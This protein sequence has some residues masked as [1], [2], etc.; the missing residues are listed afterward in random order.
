MKKFLFLAF[1]LAAGAD[2]RTRS[3]E[4]LRL[5]SIV[6]DPP[7]G[8]H[9]DSLDLTVGADFVGK[10]IGTMDL[11]LYQTGTMQVN[12]DGGPTVFRTPSLSF[13]QIAR[14]SHFL[15]DPSQFGIVSQDEN[16]DGIHASIRFDKPVVF[17]TGRH[18]PIV[19]IIAGDGHC[20]PRFGPNS[21]IYSSLDYSVTMVDGTSFGGSVGFVPE[22]SNIALLAAGLVGF[23]GWG[24]RRRYWDTHPN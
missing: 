3:Q 7:S 13:L 15:L 23:I 4:V 20:D 12:L 2:I 19:Q 18:L 22:P 16:S 6:A 21:G 24:W 5:F 10:P 17:G 11:H 9:L 8:F 14:D 1:L